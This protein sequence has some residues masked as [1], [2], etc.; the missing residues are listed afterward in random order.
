L[1]RLVDHYGRTATDHLCWMYGQGSV[2]AG[3]SEDSDL[4]LILVWDTDLPSAPTLPGQSNLTEHARLAVEQSHV[5]GY[6]VD[7][8]HVRRSTFENWMSDLE[9]GDGWTGSAWPLPIYVA[10]GLA[11]SELLLDPTGLG[12]EHRSRVQIPAARLVAKVRHRLEATLPGYVK[13]LDRASERQNRWLHAHLA[14]EL[15]KLIYT[16][17]FLVE[18]H[19]PPFPKYLSQWFERFDMDPE[20][21]RL[22][23]VYWAAHDPAEETA[24]LASLAAAVLN[25]PEP[26]DLSPSRP[27]R[28]AQRPGRP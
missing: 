21:R 19:Y 28:S 20:V 3:L 17:W 18:R 1:A 7:V 25:L 5:D 4:D 15:H 24:A 8:M 27:P 22:E 10:A 16:A 6:D 13:E 11:E 9:R 23:T 26:A 12:T 14:V 2:I